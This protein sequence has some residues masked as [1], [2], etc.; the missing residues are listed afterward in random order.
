MKKTKYLLAA[1]SFF[2]FAMIAPLSIAHAQETAVS[3]GSW[4]F[5]S[6]NRG[7][8]ASIGVTQGLTPRLEAGLSLIP[9][10][11]PDP[12]E[13]LYAEAHLGYSLAANRFRGFSQPASYINIIG[14][15]GVIAGINSIGAP[16]QTL[17]KSIF[18]RLTPITLGNAF[19][20]RRDRIYSVGALF[21]L[22]NASL[23]FFLNFIISDFFI[24][25]RSN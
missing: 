4:S 20:G 21:N 5:F 23:S 18:I 6:G 13:D 10:L 11:T 9:R 1:V 2:I 7:I 24:A 16:G 3:L 19:Y 8:F 22:D 25:K 14:D 12:F 15:I 17:T